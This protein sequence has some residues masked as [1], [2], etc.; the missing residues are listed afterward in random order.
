[1]ANCLRLEELGDNLTVD[2]YSQWARQSKNTTYQQL[3]YGGLLVQPFTL[4]PRPLW[5]NE[6]CRAVRERTDLVIRQR[7]A[8]AKRKLE[9]R[10][11]EA[12]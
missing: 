7:S 10:S 1:M 11:T 6:D 8:R 3:H 2:E 12:A 5:R 9:R 4:K